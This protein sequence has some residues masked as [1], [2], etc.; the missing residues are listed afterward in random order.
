M[1]P[2]LSWRKV[3]DRRLVAVS[4]V[5]C[6]RAHLSS[7]VTLLRRSDLMGGEYRDGLASVLAPP[8]CLCAGDPFARS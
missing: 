4:E 2:W 5:R 8:Q 3:S 7:L 6:L 1:P